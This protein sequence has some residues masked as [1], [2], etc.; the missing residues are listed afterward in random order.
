MGYW[1]G[2]KVNDIVAFIKKAPQDTPATAYCLVTVASKKEREV[3]RTGDSGSIILSRDLHQVA[4]LWA[5]KNAEGGIPDI[6]YA[7]PVVVFGH[8]EKTLGWGKGSVAFC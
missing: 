7:S 6:T 5:V 1:V 4:M 2:T 3:S 8:I